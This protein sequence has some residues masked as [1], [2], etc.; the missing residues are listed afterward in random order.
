[1]PGASCK[2]PSCLWKTNRPK[3]QLKGK[4]ARI[5]V[6]ITTKSLAFSSAVAK[7]HE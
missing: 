7:P 5:E 3:Y 1:L 4:S 2:T 6:P